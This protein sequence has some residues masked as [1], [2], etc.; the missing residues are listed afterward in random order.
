MERTTVHLICILPGD[1]EVVAAEPED[2]GIP[3]AETQK[4]AA[5]TGISA[6]PMVDTIPDFV[7]EASSLG[8][9]VEVDAAEGLREEHFII[10]PS[11]RSKEAE[12][13]C[14]TNSKPT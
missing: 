11:V 2:E 13:L 7:Q 1:N 5:L 12:M 4:E 6:I 8:S 10:A 9:R 3:I 14:K